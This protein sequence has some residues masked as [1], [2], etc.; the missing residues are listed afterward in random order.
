MSYLKILRRLVDNQQFEELKKEAGSYYEEMDDIHGL[1]LLAFA[2]AQ[3]GERKQALEVYEKAVSQLENLDSDARVDLA[4]AACALFFIDEAVKLLEP[5][6]QQKPENPL[7]LARLAWCRMQQGR[8]DE[9][10]RLYIKSTELDNR[11]PVWIALVRLCLQAKELEDARK[12]IQ[13]AVLCLEIKMAQLPEPVID[14]FTAQLRNLQ[15]EIWVA[16]A[17]FAP[18]EEWLAERRMNLAEDLWV[19]LIIVYSNLLAGSDLH[20]QAEE[21]LIEGLKHYPY[22]IAMIEHLAE[23]A[24]IQ[25]HFM[26]AI[27]ALQRAIQLDK[28]NPALWSRLANA[29]LQRFDRQARSAAEKSVELAEG[30]KENGKNPPLKL[31]NL[32][33][34]AKNVLA[35]VESR[36]QN[37]IMAETLFRENIEQ[38][39]Y[40]VPSLQ[41]LAQQYMQQGR[42]NEALELYEK[43]KRV[44]PVKAYSG[45]INAR[46]FPDDVE[47]LEQL[48]KAAEIPSLEGRIQS[49]IMFQLASAWEKRGDYEKAFEMAEK[50]NRASRM[51]ITYDAKAHRNGCARIR[52]AFCRELYEYRRGCGID[53]TLPVY[54]LGMPRS[55]TTLV[56]QI[57]AGHSK[58]FGAG[59]LGVIPQRIAG[60]NRW[61][62]YVGSGRHYPDCIDDLTPYITEG[63]ARG[64]VAELKGL[65]EKEK[66]GATYVVD[67]LPHNFE[68]IGFIRFLFPKAKV[69]SV[70]RDP[71]DIAI[72]NYF[73]DYQAKHGGMGFAYDLTDIGEQLADHNIMMHHWNQVFPGEILEINYE[74]VVDDLEKSARKMLDYIG[75]DWEP[76]VLKFNELERPVKTASLWQVRQPIYKTSKARWEHYRDKLGPL[77]RGTNAK[78]TWDRVDDM[79]TLPEPGLLQ[80][81]VELYRKGDL[82]GAE[83]SFKKMLHHNPEHAACN[84][85]VGLI[86]FAKGHME[87]GK[88]LVEKALKK[89]PWQREWR[90]NLAR[91]YQQTGQK[92]KASDLLKQGALSRDQ[93]MEGESLDNSALH[94]ENNRPYDEFQSR[95]VS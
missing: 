53:S 32:K 4:G 61:E 89:C 73:T 90:E 40:F 46:Y 9:A 70:R 51:F 21:V 38:A 7:A 83:L 54:V 17:Q 69:I 72:S 93:D 1:P 78:I 85:M 18:A 47:I 68:N 15:L 63:I 6:L 5:I 12:S 57:I 41:G 31:K 82:D 44:D 88:E 56:E 27:K 11:L 62:R 65:A 48:E 29:C 64:I 76:Q 13:N 75:V 95:D 79:L 74:D 35:F 10:K 59:E 80:N 3:L 49:G 94:W 43:I 52:H 16:C 87:E 42:I 37:Y 50:A 36:E 58:I 26:Q 34:Q 66:P 24:L 60:L 77:I 91:A 92:E 20:A 25:G 39:P 14:L 71:R 28:D 67:K 19:A 22:N 45:L 30:L 86:Y 84:Y 33:A 8:L 55:G 2:H 23:L 81:G